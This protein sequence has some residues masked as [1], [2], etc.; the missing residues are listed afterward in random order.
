MQA[1]L[2]ALAVKKPYF[3]RLGTTTNSVQLRGGLGSSVTRRTH[4]GVFSLGLLDMGEVGFLRVTF[5][6]ATLDI[7]ERGGLSDTWVIY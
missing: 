3:T 2:R 4:S 5:D 1:A 7:M 6:D